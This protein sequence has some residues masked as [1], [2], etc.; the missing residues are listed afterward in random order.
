[1]AEKL[2]F[3]GKKLSFNESFHQDESCLLAL[4]LLHNSR[5]DGG[6]QVS[7]HFDEKLSF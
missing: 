4:S 1:M 3:M 7:S 6:K 5:E 2:S